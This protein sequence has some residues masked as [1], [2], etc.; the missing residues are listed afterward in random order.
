MVDEILDIVVPQV[1]ITFISSILT[2]GGYIAIFW[3]LD[4]TKFFSIDIALFLD[5]FAIPFVIAVISMSLIWRIFG[6]AGEMI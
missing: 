4:Q 5:K 3:A 2:L 6:A 1:I